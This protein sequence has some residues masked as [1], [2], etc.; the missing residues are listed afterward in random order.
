MVTD[1]V[2]GVV[3]ADDHAPTRQR[4]RESL[5]N[6]GFQV[7][8]EAAN[9][10]RAVQIAMHHHP[11][12]AILDINMP[13]NG[14]R[15]AR[16]ISTA[17]PDTAVVMLT[18][19]IDDADLF[20]ALRAG[21]SGYL[22]KGMDTDRLP[23]ALRGVL[24]GEAAISRALVAKILNEFRAPAIRKPLRGKPQSATALLTS[25]EWEVMDLLGQGHTT[26]EA[27]RRLFVSPTTVRVHVSSVL[28]K[29]RVKD[30]QSAYNIL[31]GD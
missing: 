17:L 31:R 10:D 29:L 21:A 24:N 4:I 23:H 25:R 22:Q 27:A 9:A 8:D 11:D 14:I 15:A 3:L 12:V 6:G 28:R 30:R 26:E 2:T 19:S 16:A 1:H 20:D 7:L 13:G 5:E 18:A